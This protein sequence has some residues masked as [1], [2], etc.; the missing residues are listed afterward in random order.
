MRGFL[1]RGLLVLLFLYGCAVPEPPFG[2]VA[3]P[4]VPAGMSRVFIYRTL[5][6][7][8]STD[9][10]NVLMNGTWVGASANGAVFYRDVRPGQYTIAIPATEDYPNQFKT[11]VL[12]PGQTAYVRI[13]STSTW[14]VCPV[15]TNCYP[16][17]FVRV[18]DPAA[19]YG[20]MRSLS[21]SAG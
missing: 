14:A 10:A 21:L 4:P 5:E 7:Y 17:F 2:T 3:L 1:R 9:I 8:E 19:A 13:E 16:T 11:V 15:T 18:M 12:R 20:E 6:P